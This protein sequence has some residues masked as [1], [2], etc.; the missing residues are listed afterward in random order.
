[1][2]QF[3]FGGGSLWGTRTDIA[4]AQPVKF[5]ALQDVQLDFSGDLKP[6]Y[7]QGQY[8]LALARGKAKVEFKAK[9]AQVSGLIFNNLYFGGTLSAGQSLVA[10]GEVASIPAPLSLTTSAATASG[11]VLTFAATTGVVPGQPVTGT[12]IA[13]GSIATALTSTSVT[14]S[15]PVSGTVASGASIA[16]GSGLLAA[17]AAQ[18]QTDLGVS[19]AAS[20]LPL[21][22]V[23][24]APAAG[25]Y[26]VSAGAYGFAS[27]D[28]GLAVLLNYGYSATAGSEIA[29]VN[30]RMGFTPV[31][32]ALFSQPFQGRQANFRLNACCSSKLSFP[33]KQDDWAIPEID[34]EVSADAAGNIGLISFSE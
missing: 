29:I 19:F 6:L 4:Q 33:T 24:S 3:G 18:F 10:E 20:G 26:T 31:F 2:P 15:L 25:Q 23:A 5:G 8:A 17:N 14:L 32:S 16:F 30:P 9:F 34:F 7:G 28:A 21:V 1:M 22:W 11:N 13:A 27:A 12:G